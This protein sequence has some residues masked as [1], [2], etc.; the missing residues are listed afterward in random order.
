MIFIAQRSVIGPT[1]VCYGV[2][3]GYRMRYA[4]EVETT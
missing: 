1:I 3:R 4:L 2:F